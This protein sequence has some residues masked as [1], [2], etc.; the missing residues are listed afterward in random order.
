MRSQHKIGLL[1]AAMMLGLV[2]GVAA[3]P[4]RARESAGARRAASPAAKTAPMLQHP[5][6]VQ[7]PRSAAGG[8]TTTVFTVT[9]MTGSDCSAAIES[10]LI[11]LP[12][13]TTV[14]ADDKTGIAKVQYDPQQS[15][16][17]QLIAAIEKLGYAAKVQEEPQREQPRSGGAGGGA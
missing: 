12:G 10:A 4:Q 15:T 2:L 17:A 3:C 9:G 14:S 13:V 16:P 1:L 8:I 11:K 5:A 6:A 7:P